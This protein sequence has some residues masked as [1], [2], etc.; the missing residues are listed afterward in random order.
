MLGIGIIGIGRCGIV[1]GTGLG[2]S[3]EGTGIAAEGMVQPAGIAGTDFDGSAL[4]TFRFIAVHTGILEGIH[5]GIAVG[6]GF[7]ISTGCADIAAVEGV[8]QP[9]GIAIAC[10]DGSAFGAFR[11]I[12]VHIGILH[13]IHLC[14]AM[15]TRR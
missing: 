6:T 13:G 5:L 1:M 10:F 4:G 2:I 8:I 7:L 3:A 12:A 14:V 9:A 15:R 11:F